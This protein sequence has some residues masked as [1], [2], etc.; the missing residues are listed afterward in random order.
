MNRSDSVVTMY[1]RMT[2]TNPSNYTT[3]GN[4]I[5]TIDSPSNYNDQLRE[6]RISD[7]SRFDKLKS[8]LPSFSI[9]KFKKRN[10]KSCESYVPCLV[11]DFDKINT[12]AYTDLLLQELKKLDYVYAA[13]PSVSGLGLRVLVWTTSTEKQHKEYYIHIINLLT[14]DLGKSENFH[15]DPSTKNISRTWYYASVDNGEFYINENSRVVTVNHKEKRKS[16][17]PVERSVIT[18]SVNKK[19]ILIKAIIESRNISG[20]NNYVMEF[21]RFAKEN[22]IAQSD[23]LNELLSMATSDFNAKEITDT[24]SYNYNQTTTSYSEFQLLKYANDTLG[25][26]NVRGLLGKQSVSNISSN[27]HKVENK[28][29]YIQIKEY[30]S[31]NYK[32]RRNEI[33]LDIEYKKEDMPFYE[34]LNENDLICELME[35]NF[36]SIDR[37]LRAIL[38]SSVIVSYNPLRDYLDSLPKWDETKPDYIL[39]LG[40]YVKAKDQDRF[41]VHFRKAIVRTLACALGYIPFNKHCLVL[42]GG[43]NG[44]KTSFLRF[45]CPR[46]LKPFYKENISLDKDGQIALAQNIFINLDEL[47]SISY[48]DRNKIKTLITSEYIKVRLPYAA[49]ETKNPRIASFF[50]T[51]NDKEILT[52]ETGNVRWLLFEIDEIIHDNGGPRGY[53]RNIDIDNVYSQAYY[54]LQNGFKYELSSDDITRSEVANKDYIKPFKEL[55]LMQD[56]YSIDEAK[57]PA[58]FTTT[59]DILHHL[60]AEYPRMKFTTHMIGKALRHMDIKKE[61]GYSR[62]KRRSIRGYYLKQ[63]KSEREA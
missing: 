19:L 33:S 44:G 2:D 36:K 24:I 26:N 41:L 32:F 62:R 23:I 54:F 58:N 50:A 56:I 22:N 21:T 1:S 29:Q 38:N 37:I 9:G 46:K 15:I 18:L 14:R 51:T 43:Q 7:K 48:K 27:N 30:L 6:V 52:D 53:N 28:N 34:V 57:K 63:H 17:N 35:N 13:F 59:T 3:L 49:K 61:S 31:T 60:L 4:L 10:D 25:R 40:K 8:K 12:S 47:T 39:K 5:S 55:E 11:F 45:L 20:R 16:T 42:I